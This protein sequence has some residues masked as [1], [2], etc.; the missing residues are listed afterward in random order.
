MKYLWLDK[1]EW[2]LAGRRGWLIVG[3]L[4]AAIVL[5]TVPRSPTRIEASFVVE[6]GARAI[7]RVPVR[8]LVQTVDV[9]EGTRVEPGQRLAVLSNAELAASYRRASSDLETGLLLAADARSHGDIVTAEERLEEIEEADKRMRFS[10]KK[11]DGLTVT[12]PISGVVSTRDVEQLRGRVME[13]G[14]SLCA[15]DGLDTVKLAVAT[16]EADIEEIR[17]GTSVRMAAVG[18]PGRTMRAEVL[19]MAPVAIPPDAEEEHRLDLVQRVNLVRVLVEI[20]N[21]DG[22][23]RPGMTGRVQFITQPRSVAGKVWWRFRRWFASV[24]W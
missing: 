7:V 13:E 9:V 4:I 10:R 23:L 20:E 2:L 3:A 1:R 14:T 22:L 5:L 24:V 11:L 8:G 19:S 12:A 17:I 21:R 6:P 15:I 18:Y 16:S